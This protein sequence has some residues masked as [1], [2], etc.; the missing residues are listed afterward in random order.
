[1]KIAYKL[2]L[3]LALPIMLT[4]LV[5]LYATVSSEKSL[6]KAIEEASAAQA[7]SVMEEVDRVIHSRI[8]DWMAYG[9]S[10]E[11]QS[12]LH[13]SNARFEQL[14]DAQGQIDKMDAAWREE[15]AGSFNSLMRQTIDN[16]LAEA[17]R[18]KLRIFNEAFGF[19]VYGEVFITNRYGA[20]IAQTNRTTD[21][22]QDDEV[23]WQRA[24]RDG[25]YVA[26]IDFDQSANIFS[27][28]ICLRVND[29]NGDFIGVIKAVLNIKE[30]VDIVE[31]QLSGRKHGP[32][33]NYLL[34]NS[35]RQIIHSG[36]PTDEFLAD[37]SSYFDEVVLPTH[38]AVF[39]AYRSNE[40][41]GGVHWHLL[42]YAFSSGFS[43]FSGLGW[44]LV[45]EHDA[46]FILSPARDLRNNI[47]L[48]AFVATMA[49]L[50]FGSAIAVSISRRLRRLCAATIALGQGKLD[51]KVILSGN[52]ELTRFAD[53]FNDMAVEL[54]NASR[55]LREQAIN[56]EQKNAQLES[57]ITER[58]RA[59]D[60]L[61]KERDFAETLIETAQTI[62]LLLD[63]N[64]RIVRFN[65]YMEELTGYRLE[66]VRGKNWFETFLPERERGDIRE[67]FL[68]SLA[69][70]STSGKVNQ[71]IGKEGKRYEI[72]WHDATL[73]RGD[74]TVI[75]VLAVGQDI[76]ERAVLQSQL[77][78]A[79]K[80]EAIGQLAAGIA[81]EINTPIQFIGDNLKFCNVSFSSLGSL[82]AKYA[83]LLE[84]NRH[85]TPRLEL[86]NEVDALAAD[87]EVEYLTEE[88][89]KAIEQ[90][91]DGVNHVSSIVRS[92]KEF[93][94][95]GGSSKELTDL[96]KAI[97]STITV[98]RNEWKY[99]AEIAADLD[100]SL[101]AVPV[102]AG[103][104]NQVILNIII[105][106][107]HAIKDAIGENSDKKGVI[108]VTTRRDGDW[109]E[110]QLSDTGTGMS[111]E[112]HKKVFDPF[113]TTKDV[114]KGT[115]QGLAI[116]YATIVKKHGGTIEAQSEVGRG[117]TFIIRLPVN[118]DTG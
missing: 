15:P 28:A 117:T 30:V 97:Q 46:D 68:Q 110:M 50:T 71:I 3:V 16:D 103:D 17:M 102:L 66:E 69:G 83:Q 81:H 73:K 108:T 70:V 34:F 80:L 55:K 94:H 114:G 20:N 77:A 24:K 21:Y 31:A 93:S 99:V 35:E 100:P 109:V 85:G 115:G 75:G 29:K 62:V 41:G 79:Q 47:L 14:N 112:I 32:Y 76:T 2:A 65:R 48:L 61:R 38:G 5:V 82:L 67:R 87:I 23:W 89:P 88:L 45:I 39:T 12:M 40:E 1:M 4:W 56:L 26:E 19:P 7:H 9:Q 52:D 118:L 33:Y 51:H 78:Q 27:T 106:A 36:D 111:E 53:H 72:E 64:G 101:P 58:K 43:G 13:Q 92:M 90:S 95:P 105:N 116:A 42:T 104:F 57:N 86:V 107:T 22:R 44:S 49:A 11:V 25:M 54:K 113:F 96:N 91:L 59:E 84:A 60:A 74:E 63:T 18:A 6:S 8:A 10:P 37:G 98:T